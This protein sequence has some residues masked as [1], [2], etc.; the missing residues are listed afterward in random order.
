MSPRST[1]SATTLEKTEPVL[2]VSADGEVPPQDE[3]SAMTEPE[4]TALSEVT[5]SGS[6][7][8]LD[9]PSPGSAE[10]SG[11]TSASLPNGVTNPEDLA[12]QLDQLVRSVTAV[13]E[14]S[15]RA[16]EA[17]ANDLARYEALLA[18]SQQYGQYLDQACTLRD[19]AQQALDRAFGRAARET[20]E[21]L[22][23]QAE[24][25]LQAF[26]QLAEGWQSRASAFLGEHPD[27]DLLLAERNTQAEQARREEARAAHARRRDTLLTATQDA[28]GQGLVVEARRVLG[29]LEREFPDDTDTIDGLRQRLEACLRAEL[30]VSA[31]QV[32]AQAAEAQARGDLEAT[33][34][35]LELA[36]VQGLSREVSEDLFGRWSDACSR[37]AQTAGLK[38]VRHAPV[39]G[40]GLIL[41]SDPAYP[42]G[43]VVFSSLGMG[44]HFP[45]GKVVTDT[46][47]LR[48]SRPFREAAPL[49]TNSWFGQTA[50]VP[51]AA[52]AGPVRH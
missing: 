42:N 38:L 17:A 3:R 31:R 9:A 23:V 26:A 50:W 48:R 25:V 10:V 28:L 30:D 6:E 52:A 12:G 45:Q 39:Q 41:Y 51:T 4:P 44:P 35:I 36:E 40:R 43:L 32:L 37:L 19:Q 20:A 46:A 34:S 13:E 29:L 7:P 33:V 8:T 15:Q 5:D 27:V 22:V 18:S 47:I 11:A 1:K 14:L 24:Q 2:A 49:P 21:R 16:R